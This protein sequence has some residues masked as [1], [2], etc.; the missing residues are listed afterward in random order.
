MSIADKSSSVLKRDVFLLV[1]RIFT[2][3]IIA[4]KLGPEMLGILVILMLIPSYAEAFG[5][6][7]FDIAAV[8]F[9]GKRK[10]ALGEV[11]WTLNLLALVTSGLIVAVILWQFTWLYGLLFSKSNLDVTGLIYLVLLGIPLH[12]L[13]MNY[14]YL[15]L[16]REDIATY[17]WMIII[18]ALVSSLFAIA[19]LFLTE[20]GLWAVV[21]ASVLATLL[22]LVYG[23]ARLGATGRVGTRL[24][25]PLIRD[26]FQ[27]GSK[28]YAGGIVGQ[29][30]AYLTNLLVAM[31]LVPAQVAF[32][33]LARG[34]GQMIDR[35]PAALNTIL[36]PRLTKI[37][38]GRE[39]AELAARAFRYLLALL[40]VVGVLAAALAYPAVY[41]L[42]GAN[43]LPLV[44]PFL[45]L[46]PGVLAAGATTPFMQYFMSIN[47]TDLGI[48]LPIPPLALQ[49][50][51]ALWLIPRL[52]PEGAAIAFSGSLLLFALITVWMFVKVSKSITWLDFMIRR[53]D[54]RYLHG[55]ALRQLSTLMTASRRK[56]ARVT[57][58]D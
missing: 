2:S 34:L 27:Y 43:Y 16:H 45:I 41:I 50:A 17:N 25:R 11:V 47:R 58:A 10:Y 32:F 54:L 30:Q 5:R 35:V 21:G 51:T 39:A 22:S 55:Y 20:L 33:S 18:N 37:D 48:T 3:A 6:L 40:L 53:E 12:F 38:D 23:A 44:G 52:G 42:Y 49:V 36:F 56:K 57:H 15:L 1:T 28:L 19:L 4:R 8:Y 24:N 46:I 7:K 26:L 13:W 31:F 14:S 29:L 9:L